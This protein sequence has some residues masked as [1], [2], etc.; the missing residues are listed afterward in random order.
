MA[1]RCRH[2]RA[3]LVSAEV[4][5]ALVCVLSTVVKQWETRGVDVMA[6]FLK[7]KSFKG[8]LRRCITMTMELLLPTLMVS[9]FQ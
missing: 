8:C 3:G 9:C 7:A 4:K 6:T 5:H 1:G 2:D